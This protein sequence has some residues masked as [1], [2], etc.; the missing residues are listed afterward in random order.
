LSFLF[1]NEDALSTTHFFEDGHGVSVSISALRRTDLNFD[2]PC[3]KING[4]YYRDVLLTRDFLPVIRQH[5]DKSQNIS[6]VI[7]IVIVLSRFLISYFHMVM[8][9]HS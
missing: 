7:V 8:H 5:S 3:I 4:K 1:E 9:P 6:F 2:D